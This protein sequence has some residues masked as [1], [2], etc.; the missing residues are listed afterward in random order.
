MLLP[1]WLGA[2]LE[3]SGEKADAAAAKALVRPDG[4]IPNCP[5]CMPGFCGHTMGLFLHCM[6]SLNDA[7][8]ARAAAETILNSRLL[9]MYGTV[10][11]FYGPSCTPNGHNCRPFEGGIVGEALLKYFENL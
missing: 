7:D 10:S 5:E 11:E 4:F 1:L 6:L 2:K 9:S 8:A 3:N